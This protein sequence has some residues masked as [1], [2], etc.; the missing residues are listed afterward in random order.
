MR[1]PQVGRWLRRVR[2]CTPGHQVEVKTEHLTVRAWLSQDKARPGNRLTLVAEVDLPQRTH[3]YAPGVEGYRP[4]AWTIETRSDLAI[5]AP[6]F[7]PSKM[8]KLEAINERVPVFE[9][10]VRITRDATISAGVRASIIEWRAT[11]EYQACDDEV[12]YLPEKVPLTFTVQME[13][14]DRQRVPENMRRKAPGGDCC[15]RE[16]VPDTDFRLL[17]IAHKSDAFDHSGIEQDK[18]LALPLDRLRELVA[19]GIVG[20]LAPR[21]FS[22]LGSI[23]APRKLIETSAPEVAT[24]LRD[25]SIDGVLL[26]LV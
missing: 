10:K 24:E 14:L 26:T 1:C 17:K 23:P 12:C 19:N 21:H 15:H 20:S 2:F 18:N 16:I 4:T 9:S 8:M 25:D 22:F 7:P 11:L 3:I 5:H 13:S 6:Q